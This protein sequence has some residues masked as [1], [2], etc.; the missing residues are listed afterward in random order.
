MH[1]SHCGDGKQANFQFHIQRV[2]ATDAYTQIDVCA[3]EFFV[4]VVVI[5]C[6]SV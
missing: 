6:L 5:R 4:V 3:M 2:A 1:E